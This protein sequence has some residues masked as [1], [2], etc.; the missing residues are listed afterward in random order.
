MRITPYQFL[1]ADQTIHRDVNG[2]SDQ[3]CWI[4]YT[5]KFPVIFVER[6]F[7]LLRLQL[8]GPFRLSK[9]SL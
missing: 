9:P 2:P 7:E 6:Q 1:L 4:A 5:S 8:R 3:T